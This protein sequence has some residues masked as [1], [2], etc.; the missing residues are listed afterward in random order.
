MLDLFPIL[1]FFFK[2]FYQE[3]RQ[4]DRKSDKKWPKRIAIHFVSLLWLPP[5]ITLLYLNFSPY[6]IGLSVWCPLG[7]GSV[8]DNNG[9]YSAESIPHFEKYHHSTN[10]ML[11]FAA[12]FLDVWFT[13]VAGLLVF[14][15]QKALCKSKGGL[16]SNYLLMD[17]E[18]SPA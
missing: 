13:S 15:A 18:F 6:I 14:E 11:L 9:R 5:I 12:K 10:G 7:R 8:N 17:L 1:F 4:P 2:L 3:L 16:P